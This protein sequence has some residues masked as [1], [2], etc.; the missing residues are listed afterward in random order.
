MRKPLFL[1]AAGLG[2]VLALAGC[3]AAPTDVDPCADALRQAAYETMRQL[4]DAGY[5]ADPAALR[6]AV[7]DAIVTDDDSPSV[8]LPPYE[9]FAAYT[10]GEQATLLSSAS[11]R[12][13]GVGD[14]F[15]VQ[16]FY[17]E[18][19]ASGACAGFLSR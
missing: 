3:T 15:D 18:S 7:P 2:A 16:E 14:L 13:E 6:A 9:T 17:A 12:I 5:A 8:A 11:S 10:D 19:D 4:A 1:F